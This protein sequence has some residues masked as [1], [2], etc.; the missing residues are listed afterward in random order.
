MYLVFIESIKDV[1]D[2]AIIVQ[3]EN[4]LQPNPHK[5]WKKPVDKKLGN[6]I[7]DSEMMIP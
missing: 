3:I 5:W 4:L 7:L 2:E 6:G 1:Q